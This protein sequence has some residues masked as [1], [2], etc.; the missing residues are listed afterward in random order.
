M[1]HIYFLDINYRICKYALRLHIIFLNLYMWLIPMSLPIESKDC[2][3]TLKERTRHFYNNFPNNSTIKSVKT[4]VET[5]ATR[6][7]IL[8]KT[9]T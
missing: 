8:L 4:Y 3:E 7:S 1:S 2:S 5:F 6:Y 9:K